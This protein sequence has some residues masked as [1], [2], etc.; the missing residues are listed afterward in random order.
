MRPLLR[1]ARASSGTTALVS[2]APAT[3]HSADSS[4]TEVSESD[5]AN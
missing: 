5:D 4:A 2:I 3:A 1:A